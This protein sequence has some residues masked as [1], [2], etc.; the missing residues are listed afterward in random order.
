MQDILVEYVV[1]LAR[2]AAGD[3]PTIMA[4]DMMWVLRKV[5][6]APLHAVAQSDFGIPQLSF[7]SALRLSPCSRH[8]KTFLSY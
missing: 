8:N 4:Q 6:G 3:K 2:K 1:E 7:A 5:C